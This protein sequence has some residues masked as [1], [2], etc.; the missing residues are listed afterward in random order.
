MGQDRQNDL[1]EAGA[2]ADLGRLNGQEARWRMSRLLNSMAP[3]A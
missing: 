2:T 3:G 1:F